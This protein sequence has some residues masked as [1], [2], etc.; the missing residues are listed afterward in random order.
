MDPGQ[1]G[2]GPGEARPSPALAAVAPP[3]P[4]YLPDAQPE[5]PIRLQWLFRALERVVL[6]VEGASRRLV[7]DAWNPLLHSGAVANTL[8]L[9]ACATGALL[10]IWYSPSVHLAHASMRALEADFLGS[11]VRAAHRYSS[12]GCLAFVLWHALKLTAARRFTGA[13]WLAWVTGLA[14]AGLLWFIGWLGYWLVWDEAARQVALGTARV[15]DVLPIFA[16]PLSREFVADQ[17]INSLL[18]FVVFFAHMVIPLAMG[19]A[20][21]LHIARLSRSDFLVSKQVA[22]VL[23][24]LTLALSVAAPPLAA[25]AATMARVPGQFT[26]DAWY[27]APLWLT[28]RL[29][30]GVLFALLVGGGAVSFAVPWLLVKKKPRP[31]DIVLNNCTGCQDCMR[32]CPYDAI[33]MVPRTDGKPFALQ[34]LVDPSRCVG[35]G[36]CTGSCKGG[37]S[38]LPHF[39]MLTE[40]ARIEQ[41]IDAAPAGQKPHLA[42]LCHDS[43]GDA[44]EVD[45]ATG[46]CA[47]L[48]G[49]RVMKVPC[50][51][52]VQDI[53]LE[54]ALRK[55][56]P[57]ILI[58]ACAGACRYREGVLWTQERLDGKRTPSLPQSAER[59]RILLVEHDR[60]EGRA[61]VAA[62]RAFR[63]GRPSAAA[64]RLPRAAGA[65]VAAGLATAVVWAGQAVPYQPPRQQGS[66]LVFSFRHPGRIDERCTPVS[67]EENAKRP[68]HMRKA[69]ECSRG[70]QPVRVKVEL[71]GQVLLQKAYPAAGLWGDGPSIG[72]E[73]LAVA[74]GQHQVSIQLGD[75]ADPGEWAF[76]ELRAVEF[77]EGQLPAVVFDRG[78]GFQWHL[79]PAP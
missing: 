20:L 11:A 65:A 6:W 2:P 63:E 42:F 62:A 27:L 14:G 61:L 7:P 8:L 17:T 40:R 59:A 78:K 52:W 67:E 1:S 36:I 44:L 56:T 79:P 77:V 24:G 73:R 35:C 18:F 28:D 47:A 15:L 69:E 57:G 29:P 71:D 13:R 76:T 45:F 10:L 60:T 39:E 31:A 53:T 72:L 37:G 48:P 19:V 32:D 43:A 4:E 30:G 68:V 3:R 22:V 66:G 58:S 46:A 74:P 50:A 54:R 55:G 34:A 16:D 64:R 23:V 26:F 41:W 38:V 21:W 70:R 5:P 25:A 33:T 12:D 75:S 9:V 51:G 49:Y